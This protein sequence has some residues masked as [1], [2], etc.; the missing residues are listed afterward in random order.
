MLGAAPLHIAGASLRG[1]KIL[2]WGAA[3]LEWDVQ[4]GTHRQVSAANSEFGEGG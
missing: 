1:A 2:T 4:A 3:L